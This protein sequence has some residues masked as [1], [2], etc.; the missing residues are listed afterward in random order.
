MKY[1]TITSQTNL[2]FI[3]SVITN[4]KIIFN[5]SEIASIPLKSLNWFREKGLWKLYAF[6]LMPNHIHFI[7]RIPLS[8]TIESLLARFHSFTS[9]EI[10][11]YL[12]RIKD[13]RLLDLF[14]RAAVNHKPDRNYLLWEDS[15]V[16]VIESRNVFLE[17]VEYMHNNPL[18]RKWRLAQI[19]TD[20]P[21]SSACYYDKGISPIIPIDDIAD[22][23]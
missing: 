8:M 22:T 18:S 14:H 11:N 21:Y 19:R 16:R 13:K 4:H 3:S 2:Y 5:N 12:Q 17:L 23:I 15:V 10:V 7:I 20:Y 6:C 9:H 1:K